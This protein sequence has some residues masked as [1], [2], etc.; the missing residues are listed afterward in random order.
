MRNL[1]LDIN[2]IDLFSWAYN[3]AMD[4]FKV[5]PTQASA[6]KQRA[7]R[8]WVYKRYVDRDDLPEKVLKYLDSLESD[9]EFMEFLKDC[10]DYIEEHGTWK[11]QLY[12]NVAGEFPESVNKAFKYL[13]FEIGYCEN[14]EIRED[15]LVLYVEELDSYR[16][17]LTLHQTG[18][19]K[20]ENYDCLE[21]N[22][23]QILKDKT[24]YKLICIAYDYVQELSVPMSMHFEYAT[25]EVELFRAD[26]EGRGNP[27]EKLEFISSMILSKLNLREEYLN[28]A[29]IALLPL[30][31]ELS[32]LS[33][34][35]FNRKEE[36][37]AFPVLKQYLRKHHLEKIISMLDK[38]ELQCSKKKN[39]T[40]L[41]SQINAKLC[42]AKC[43]PLWR[44]LYSLIKESQESYSNRPVTCDEQLVTI[45]KRIEQNL[46]EQGYTGEYP[47]F[48]KKGNMKKIHLER[49]YGQTY[50]VGLEK[51]VEYI[52]QCYESGFGDITSI[53]F[54][55]GTALLKKNEKVED[56]YSCCFNANGRR[57]V[58]TI[59]WDADDMESLD[60]I[61][62]CAVERAECTPLN[63][64]ERKVI[65]VVGTSM[66]EFIGIVLVCGGLFTV[67]M[68]SAM[69]IIF[70][71]L[72]GILF[73]IS[74]VPNLL[75][76][77]PWGI[78]SAF[79]FFGFGITLAVCERLAGTK[80]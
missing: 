69:F 3:F 9:C 33:I 26:D 54:M 62:M 55:C 46:H 58:K 20:V 52:I 45:R 64:E 7:I 37:Y 75:K 23:A 8:K 38:Y 65:G 22:E 32:A 44:E 19:N 28:Q 78:L 61:T 24:G 73:G 68:M 14:I 49:S 18:E 59:F 72:D 79:C 29:E 48:R 25:C 60:S 40:F 10:A 47:I 17:V 11:Q 76:E 4:V 53:G 12:E 34:F 35:L 57:L 51:N 50:F 67:L 13:F 30:L 27:W 74:D 77:M 16:Q 66:A 31:K 21:F 42:E 71:V 6:R 39:P 80:G 56:I 1:E 41:L 15:E 2:Y 36:R 63:K 43:E 5:E 70:C